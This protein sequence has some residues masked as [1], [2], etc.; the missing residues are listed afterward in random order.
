[1]RNVRTVAMVIGAVLSLPAMGLA[2]TAASAMRIHETK[3]VVRFIDPIKLEITAL[4]QFGERR[5]TFVLNPS[6][7]REGSMKV[8]ST[9]DVR[10]RGEAN[11]RIATDVTVE[12][13]KELP[14]VS[15]LHQ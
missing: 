7:E 11:R 10:Y 4:P 2:A 8:G 3:G 6:T 5:M 13:A 1:M 15:A 12:H 14:S 9:V